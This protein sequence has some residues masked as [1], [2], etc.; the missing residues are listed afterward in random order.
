[1]LSD[2]LR[3]DTFADGEEFVP[4]EFQDLVFF[5]ENNCLN[6]PKL[7]KRKDEVLG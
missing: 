7:G 2:D 1:L 4:E 5:I 6:C 3:Q